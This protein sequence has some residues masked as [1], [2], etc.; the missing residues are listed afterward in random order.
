MRKLLTALAAM[1]LGVA[2]SSGAWAQDDK[3]GAGN[4]GQNQGQDKGQTGEQT[5]RGVIAGIAVEGE[6]VIDY[7]T[8]RAVVLEAAYLTVVGSPVK[9]QE[10]AA[11]RSKESGQQARGDSSGKQRE[12]IYVVWLSPRTKIYAASDDS[13]KADRKEVP[14]DVLEVGDRVQVQFVKREETDANAGDNQN[15]QR[16]RKHGR[17]RIYVGDASAITILPPKSQDQSSSGSQGSSKGNTDNPNR[18]K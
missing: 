4:S 10:N 12:N 15:E 6:T 11:S 7:R 8:N 3:P 5:I 2:L 18:D 1:G 16:R 13:G 17:Q 9:G 14:L